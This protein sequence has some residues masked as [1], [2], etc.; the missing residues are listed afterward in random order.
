MKALKPLKWAGVV[1]GGLVAVFAAA[2][3]SPPA[4]A[5]GLTTDPSHT[6]QATLPASSEL[7]PVLQRACGDCHSNVMKA[8]WYTQVAPLSLVMARAAIDGRKAVNFDEWSAY[9][10]EQRRAFLVASCADA[11]AGTMPIPVYLRFRPDAALS[12]RDV[13]TICGAS[14]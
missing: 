8:G 6:I 4:E 9:S 5:T 7:G 1:L 10:P 3:L 12:A 11:R 13:E 2:Q 14:H